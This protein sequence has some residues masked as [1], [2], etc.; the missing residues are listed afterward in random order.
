MKHQ[1]LCTHRIKGESVNRWQKSVVP[2]IAEQAIGGGHILYHGGDESDIYFRGYVSNRES[3]VNQLDV[4]EGIS[5]NEL[6]RAAII[7]WGIDFNQHVHGDY[8]FCWLD[9]DK[10]LYF[11]ASAR[12]SHTLFYQLAKEQN[13]LYRFWI[14]DCL[15]TL[16]TLNENV[17]SKDELSL[18]LLFGVSN[19]SNT[20]FEGLQ[21][22]LPG[23]TQVWGLGEVPGQVCQRQLTLAEQL[24]LS[25][26]DLAGHYDLEVEACQ[27]ESA[28]EELTSLD[29]FNRLPKLSWAIGQPI[30]DA[31]LI[32]FSNALFSCEEEIIAVGPAWLSGRRMIDVQ[33][34][35]KA[36]KWY[37]KLLHKSLKPVQK[38]LSSIQQR[39]ITEY[40]EDKSSLPAV[41]ELTLNQW[42][43]L[44]YSLPAWCRVLQ[45]LAA[46]S[47][48]MLVF[49]CLQQEKGLELVKQKPVFSPTF[50]LDDP[51]VCNIFDSMQRLM[52]NGY[53]QVTKQILV[54]NPA[55]TSVIV[56]HLPEF[57]QRVEQVCI[58]LITLDY[59]SRFN[60]WQ[61]N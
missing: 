39:L 16:N 61:V 4:E 13:G 28:T 11:F 53:Q 43:D 54:P 10:C 1:F 46:S 60:Q 38:Q 2:D 34:L 49:C 3:L 30:D 45:R 52:E 32:D 59:L 44:K 22:L 5:R 41:N 8:V 50:T 14:T 55:T 57:P 19:E 42:F 37:G 58:Q 25:G 35:S 6:L 23:E 29:K 24:T 36:G 15:A 56:K 48:K 7:R 47:E 26:A 12:S 33:G 18:Q 20:M 9:S 17:L 31:Q 27:L 51:S 21:Q 40:E